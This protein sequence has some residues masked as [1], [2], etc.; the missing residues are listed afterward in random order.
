MHAT[1]LRT[2]DSMQ[3]GVDPAAFFETAKKKTSIISLSICVEKQASLL[4]W[5]PSH[6][7]RLLHVNIY[8]V[9]RSPAVRL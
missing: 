2:W 1:F 8:S 4:A 5:K 3:A 9:R 7:C 6:Q